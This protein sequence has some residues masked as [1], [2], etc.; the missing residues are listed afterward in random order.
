MKTKAVVVDASYVL[1]W[2][3]PD[4]SRPTLAP[5]QRVAPELLKYEIINALRSN[6]TRERIDKSIA[7][8]LLNELANWQIEYQKI[9]MVEA[10]EL[11]LLYKISGYDASYL[12]L[13]KKL[14]CKLLTWDKKLAE[15]T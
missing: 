9:D 6:V 2:L 1:S 15:I 11:A 14:K 5:S 8:K 4:E 3:L 12:W 7:K 13:A 10:L